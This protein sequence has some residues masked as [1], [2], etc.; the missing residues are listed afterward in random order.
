MVFSGT[1]AFFSSE[2]FE[3]A[4]PSNRLER[5][6]YLL[7]PEHGRVLGSFNSFRIQ[8][9]N[10]RIFR[11]NLVSGPEGVPIHEVALPYS[12]PRVKLGEGFGSP[13]DIEAPTL[14]W[15]VVKHERLL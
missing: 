9:R 15:D 13:K 2:A 4:K 5:K 3:T 14:R 8:R 6:R 1:Q 10:A 7:L 12:F 11:W